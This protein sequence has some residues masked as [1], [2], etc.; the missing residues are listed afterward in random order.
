MNHETMT[1][2]TA[3][4]VERWNIQEQNPERTAD[5]GHEY[6]N[7]ELLTFAIDEAWE[8]NELDFLTQ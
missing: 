6:S 2:L 7:E 3:V 4:L 8:N 5:D 1:K